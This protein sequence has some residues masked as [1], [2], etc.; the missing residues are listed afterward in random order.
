M[1]LDAR[2]ILLINPNTNRDTTAMMQLLAQ[3][4]LIGSPWVVD[5]LTVAEG[6]SMIVDPHSL[7]AAAV[8][9]RSAVL[10]AHRNGGRH[11][12][13]LIAAIGDPGRRELAAVLDIPVIGIGEASI[14]RAAAGGRKFG[15]ATSTPLL[16]PS[17]A[18][19]VAEHEQADRFTGVRLTKSDPLALAAD[20]ERQFE[21][22]LAA[23]GQCADDGAEAVIIAGGPLSATARRL[24]GA[25]EIAI[26]EPIPSGCALLAE[27][28]S[29]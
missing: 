11:E 10:S 5:A 16:A 23:V 4:A 3:Q 28:M 12:A 7:Q 8:Q 22:L 24:A 20:P 9:V 17:L 29:G 15:M 27:R 6:P 18:T 19:L 2:R 1:P 25:C 26:V 21:E 13:I 14:L